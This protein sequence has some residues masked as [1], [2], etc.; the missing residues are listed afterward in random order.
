MI[1]SKSSSQ[2]LNDIA[3]SQIL[4]FSIQNGPFQRIVSQKAMII[5]LRIV[6]SKFF[7]VGR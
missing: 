7:C 2:T 4:L 3:T 5:I 6:V 1:T